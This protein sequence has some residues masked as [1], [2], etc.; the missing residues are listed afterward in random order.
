MET[1]KKIKEVVSTFRT[2]AFKWYL[3]DEELQAMNYYQ[4]EGF[5]IIEDWEGPMVI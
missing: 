5:E 3:Y 1:G 4:G 2:Q